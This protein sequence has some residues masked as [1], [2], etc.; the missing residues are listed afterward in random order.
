MHPSS[1]ERRGFKASINGAESAIQDADHNPLESDATPTRQVRAAVL[2]QS[3]LH[4]RPTKGPRP[5]E[6]PELS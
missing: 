4:P 2:K 6:H 1:R 3:E 5:S